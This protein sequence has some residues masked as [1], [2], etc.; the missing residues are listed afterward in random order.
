LKRFFSVLLLTAAAGAAEQTPFR[1]D[2]GEFQWVDFR[3]NHVPTEVD[4]RFR[5][6][7][8]DA[9]VHM[10]LLSEREFDQLNKDDSHA[11]LAV[12]Q[13]GKSGQIRR[14]LDWRGRYIVAIVNKR[15]ARPAL[16]SFELRTDVNPNAQ[17]SAR[18]LSPERRLT[19]IA[20][21]FGIFFVI[22][23]FC[24]WKMMRAVSSGRSTP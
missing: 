24:G 6:V 5:V 10:E 2:S 17:S 18:E 15:G 12:S 1:L 23:A 14:L 21:S 16:V 8:G 13:D 22:V 20:I 11:T 4:C 9:S 7:R 19:V 3:V